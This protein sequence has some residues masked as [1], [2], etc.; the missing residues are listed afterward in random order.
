MNHVPNIQLMVTGLFIIQ[1]MIS[2]ATAAPKNTVAVPLNV[3]GLN[4]LTGCQ[5]PRQM[6]NQPIIGGSKETIT[7][8]TQK[9]NKDGQKT[10]FLSN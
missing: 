5:T 7:T 9:Q 8:F 6:D 1:R 2:V 4:M 3:T 10:V